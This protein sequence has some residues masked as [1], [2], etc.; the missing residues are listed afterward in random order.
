[1]KNILKKAGYTFDEQTGIWENPGFSGIAYS[2]GDEVE[3]RLA[4]VI[5][6]AADLSVLSDELKQHIIDWPSHYHLSSSRAN[7]LRP[8]AHHLAGAEVLEIGA[9]CGAIT[10]YLGEI[11]AHVLALEGSK[12]RAAIA[13]ARTRDLPQIQVL[14]ESFDG[15]Q[16][17]A[18]FDVIT[19]IGVLEYANLFVSGQNPALMSCSVRMRYSSRVVY[20]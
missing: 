20:C 8:F 1:M 19:L 7:I 12:R 13:R 16:S 11:G 6:D 18:R 5:A 9:G 2:D 15:F 10:R 4:K 17:D 3:Q 14:A